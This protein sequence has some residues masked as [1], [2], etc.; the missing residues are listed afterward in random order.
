VGTGSKVVIPGFI[1]GNKAGGDR[2]VVRGIG[3]SLSAFGVPNSLQDPTLELRDGNGALLRSNNDW[4]DNP[5]EPRNCSRRDWRRLNNLESGIALA[6]SPG[7][8]TALL[9]RRDLGTGIGVS[10]CT[11]ADPSANTSIVPWKRFPRQNVVG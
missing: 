5:V 6:L 11:T 10:K 8:Y 2:I 3:P 7:L 9:S 4:Q 1:L